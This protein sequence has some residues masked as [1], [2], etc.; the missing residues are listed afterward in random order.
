[1]APIRIRT[2]LNAMAYIADVAPRSGGTT[3]WP[4]SHKRMY[5]AFEYE[6][7]GGPGSSA[8]ETRNMTG[9]SLNGRQL[10]YKQIFDKAVADIEPVEIHGEA[11][12]VIFCTR[13]QFVDPCLNARL[14]EYGCRV[15]SKSWRVARLAHSTQGTDVCCTPREFIE[16]RPSVLQSP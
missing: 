4:G 7:N 14:S 5:Y 10:R 6:S 8:L 16:A 1:M 2:Q 12:D 15:A 13:Q 9:D 11:G 3:F